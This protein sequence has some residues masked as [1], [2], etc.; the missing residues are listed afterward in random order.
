MLGDEREIGS[1]GGEEVAK[2]DAL[3]ELLTM[4]LEP[5]ATVAGSPQT[6]PTSLAA[7]GW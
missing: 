3:P 2:G 4:L 1:L 5:P 7:A 6:G